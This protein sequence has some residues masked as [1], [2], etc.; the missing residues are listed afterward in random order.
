MYANQ[1]YGQPFAYDDDNRLTKV[2]YRDG[3]YVSY[4]YDAFG[5][6]VFREEQYFDLNGPGASTF[7]PPCR[8]LRYNKNHLPIPLEEAVQHH[9]I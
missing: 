3:T 9:V 6:K 4:A 5:R 8:N 1:Q 7:T 2:S